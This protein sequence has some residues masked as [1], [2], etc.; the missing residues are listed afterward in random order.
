MRIGSLVLVALLAVVLNFTVAAETEPALDPSDETGW[1]EVAPDWAEGDGAVDPVEAELRDPPPAEV[2][3]ALETETVEEPVDVVAWDD[4]DDPDFEPG[5]PTPEASEDSAAETDAVPVELEVDTASAPAIEIE[6]P[7][8]VVNG[9]T[10]GPVGVDS[11]GRVGRVHTVVPGDTLWDVSNAYLGTAWVWPSVWN[12]N[13]EIQNP[14]LIEPGARLWISSTE[15]R[16]ISDAEAE[17]Y[18]ADASAP[19]DESMDGYTEVAEEVPAAND[20]FARMA[21]TDELEIG[22]MD[23]LPVGMPDAGK[24]GRGTG[25]VVRVSMR[26]NMGFVSDVQL[27]ASTTILGSPSDRRHLSLLDTI[28]LGLGEGEVEVGDEFTFYRNVTGVRSPSSNRLIGYHVDV[29][30][31]AEVIEVTGDTC[32]AVIR[33]SL[34]GTMRGDRVM[35]RHKM[36]ADIEVKF[37]EQGIEGE[38]AFMPASRTLMATS[39]YVFV[40]VGAVQG[41]EIGTDLEVYDP[42]Y[43]VEDT[44]RDQYVMTPDRVIADLVVVTVQEESAVAFVAHTRRALAVGDSVRGATRDFPS[45]F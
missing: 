34:E 20:E 1:V 3:A 16:P 28:Y 31:W 15:I 23:Q 9:V 38:V 26:E 32:V 35:P 37:A 43:R 6:G 14:H 27:R 18:L 8:L 40:D 21:S 12:D 45:A 11:E 2:V 30:G 7:T 25:R 29:L 19:Q 10:L 17:E 24:Q 4:F 44:S 5:D 13:G 36:P 41:V 33:Q 42:G 22:E 39:D